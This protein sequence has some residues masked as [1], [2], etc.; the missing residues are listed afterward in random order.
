TEGRF[1]GPSGLRRS[2]FVVSQ[3]MA[4]K[5]PYQKTQ[6]IRSYGSLFLLVGI[7]CLSRPDLFFRKGTCTLQLILA[8]IKRVNTG[9]FLAV[10]AVGIISNRQK[11][12][13]VS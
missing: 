7:I 11:T 4:A 5:A 6:K 3:T 9:K 12:C 13:P 8:V 2:C 1:S 10:H